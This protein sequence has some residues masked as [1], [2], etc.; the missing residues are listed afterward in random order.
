MVAIL[1]VCRNLFFQKTL[2]CHLVLWTIASLHSQSHGS[3]SLLSNISPLI[4]IASSCLF[5]RLSCSI[6]VVIVVIWG[7]LFLLIVV[8]LIFISILFLLFLVVIVRFPTHKRTTSRSWHWLVVVVRGGTRH[9]HGTTPH[10]SST[11]SS[12]D[13]LSQQGV[14][15]DRSHQL[16]KAAIEYGIGRQSIGIR[17][18]AQ[19]NGKNQ[20]QTRH[21]NHKRASVQQ[22]VD[23]SQY[24]NITTTKK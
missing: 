18:I 6:V 16:L 7:F 5:P 17:G 9:A 10:T 19:P 3:F 8:I 21:D 12:T 4:E 24:S 15:I 22:S 13:V 11:E 1:I 23:D 14:D 20:G 2:Y